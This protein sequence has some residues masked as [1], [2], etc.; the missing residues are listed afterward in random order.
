MPILQLN[1]APVYQVGTTLLLPR[2]ALARTPEMVTATVDR[3]R[4]G[5]S[6][7]IYTLAVD[8]HNKY[9]HWRVLSEGMLI[10]RVEAVSHM[11]V[12]KVA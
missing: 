7:W 1:E 11:P 5:S 2:S 4:K 8:S 12:K 9:P 6:D 3:V 10:S